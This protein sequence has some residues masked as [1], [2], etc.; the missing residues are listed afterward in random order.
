MPDRSEIQFVATTSPI[1]DPVTKFGGQPVWYEEPQW[2]FSRATGR[3]MRFICQVAIDEALFPGSVGKMAYIFMTDEEEYVD[4]TW[5]P[6]GGENA[7]IIQPGGQAPVVSTTAQATGPTLY[8]MVDEA[9]MDRL[10]AV[11]REYLARTAS[12]SE[13]AF[14]PEQ[15]RESWSDEK[16]HAYAQGLE[17]N[18]IG[19]SP[20][21]LQYDEFPDDGDWR[22]LLQLDSTSVPFS[23]NFG[24]AGIAY[25]FIDPTGRKGRM[26]WQ[27]A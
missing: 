26:L 4:G 23:V 18:K 24:D 13:P 7:V 3:P 19:G 15:E 11:E 6:D 5:E 25:A 9:G 10:V 22:L 16:F 1:T 17:G 2:P 12:G 14:Q 8:D 20:I 27:C 21:F